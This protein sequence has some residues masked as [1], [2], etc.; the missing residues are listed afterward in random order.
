MGQSC[1]I[2][3]NQTLP[4]FIDI[5]QIPGDKSVSHRSII[6]SSLSESSVQ[7]NGFLCSE[8]CLHTV[9]IFQAMGVPIDVNHAEQVVTVSGVGLHGLQAPNQR[10]DVGNSGTGI[11]L[12]A[13]VL[14]GQSF[15]TCIT[16]DASI[17]RRPMN[18]ILTPLSLMGAIIDGDHAPLTIRG[19]QSLSGIRYRLPV[20]SAQVKSCILLAGLYADGQT[21]VIEPEPCRDH[22]ERM[23]TLFGV[24]IHK[25]GHSIVVQPPGSLQ[26]QSSEIW[27]PAD[28]SSAAFFIVLA[29]LKGKEW[30]FGHVGLNPTRRQ[31]IDVLLSMGGMITLN[32]H[33]GSYEPMGDI[34]V[35]RSTLS[36]TSVPSEWIPFIIDEI[37]ILA[38]A[39]LFSDRPFELRGIEELRVKESDR[40]ATIVQLVEAMGGRITEFPDGFCIYPMHQYRDFS[41]DCHSDHRL[42]MS[43]IIGALAAN[44]S[45][46]IIGYDSIYTS[47]P[48]F[49]SILEQLGVTIQFN[50]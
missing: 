26:A 27:V 2:S 25:E 47:F 7:V 17:Q 24:P 14:A 39:A 41:F 19:G 40:I 32:P 44:V 36:S 6:L 22:T 35:Q 16:G 30:R 49:F 1:T 21:E 10:L 4:D 48:N 5:N 12:I 9:N 18:R 13:G 8:D 20:A 50:G 31:I 29:L 15:D 3:A 42:A 43:A 23:L 33:S 28:V 11:R 37:P 34:S 38:I 46:D 45:C